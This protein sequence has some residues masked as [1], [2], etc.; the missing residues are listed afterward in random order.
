MVL[1]V[2]GKERFI[3]EVGIVRRINVRLMLEDLVLSG[4]GAVLLV[5]GFRCLVLCPVL[6]WKGLSLRTTI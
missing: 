2:I 5:V 4:E 1:K 6:K 3:R